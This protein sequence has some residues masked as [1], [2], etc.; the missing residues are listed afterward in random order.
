MKL[1]DVK[2]IYTDIKKTANTAGVTKSDAKIKQI[3]AD[4]KNGLTLQFIAK[5]HTIATS[6]LAKILSRYNVRK[7]GKRGI[8][9]L[10]RDMCITDKMMGMSIGEIA[11]KRGVSQSWLVKTIRSHKL[12]KA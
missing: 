9:A 12:T 5:K 7:I 2:R 8:S 1:S 4:Y 11:E 3:L 10:T 6:T